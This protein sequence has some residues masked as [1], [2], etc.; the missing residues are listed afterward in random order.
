MNMQDSEPTPVG[1]KIFA[2]KQQK[3]SNKSNLVAPFDP[4]AYNKQA[5][6]STNTT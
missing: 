5:K 2:T 6:K 1:L 4:D 3:S